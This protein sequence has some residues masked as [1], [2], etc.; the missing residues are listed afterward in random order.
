MIGGFDRYRLDA[1]LA[2]PAEM[3]AAWLTGQ[4]S[5]RHSQL[6]PQQHGMLDALAGLGY[7]PMRCGFPY[8]RE[9]LVEPYRRESLVAASIRNAAQY[10]AS[11]GGRRFGVE[12]ARH[13]RPLVERTSD[14][15]LLLCG[16]CG[17]DLFA[18]ALPHIRLDAG[19]PV[20]TVVALGPVGRVPTEDGRITVRVVRGD[21]DRIS[22]W[23]CREPADVVV[24]GGHLDYAAAP[25]VRAAVL[26]LAREAVDR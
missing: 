4:S 1:H 17:A 9:A 12:V 15:L 6:S 26:R 14:H 3:R 25:A 22:R 13:L 11:R 20:V 23:G 18:A 10:V 24:P 21:R 7:V 2:G 16:S 5:F 8:N 19:R